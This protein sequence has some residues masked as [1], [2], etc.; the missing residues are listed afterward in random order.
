MN[1]YRHWLT[2]FQ[3]NDLCDFTLTEEGLLWLKLRSIERRELLSRFVDMA[4]LSVDGHKTKDKMEDIWQQ[5]CVSDGV[6]EAL[7]RFLERCQI[8]EN[9]RIKDCFETIRSNLYQMESF[10]WGGGFRNSLDKAIV[11]RFVKTDEIVPYSMLEGICDGELKAMSRGYLLNSWYDYWSSV[12]VE[13]I[14]RRNRNVV[15]APGKIKNVDFFV[16]DVPFDLKVTYLP[17]E[18]AK[19]Q[20][21]RL[22]IREPVQVL[23]KFAREQRIPFD[24]SAD[25]EHVRYEIEQ[26]I[27]D[28]NQTEGLRVLDA[29]RGDWKRLVTE[30]QNNPRDLAKWLYENQGDMRFGAENRVFVILIDCDEPQGSWKLKRNV[31]LIEP[32][33]KRWVRDFDRS[34]LNSLRTEFSFRGKS[35]RTFSDVIFVCRQGAGRCGSDGD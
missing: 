31:E 34:G 33:V 35:Y 3:A 17:K 5:L 4:H 21:K 25:P 24:R 16:K 30:A 7:G 23:K 10:H 26:R 29:I 6:R 12:L 14:F 22:G 32:S 20:M 15:P 11:S 19:E 18:Y 28:A 8:E 9:R 13:N 2:R 1:A 27:R